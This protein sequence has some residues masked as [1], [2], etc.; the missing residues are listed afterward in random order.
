SN[1]PGVVR[2]VVHL[3]LWLA[4]SVGLV[5]LPRSP[6]LFALV[7]LDR[8]LIAS[9]FAPL[10]QA[11]HQ[12][13]FRWRRLHTLLASPSALAFG[14]PP[15]RSRLGVRTGRLSF[16]PLAAHPSLEPVKRPRAARPQRRVAA[17]LAGLREPHAVA[18]VHRVT[19]EA[20]DDRRAC[21]RSTRDRVASARLR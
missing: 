12:T 1:L 19:D 15:V 2:S 18:G 21:A 20:A 3:G 5:V 17:E 14:V 8:V 16:S 13:V 7:P 6:L 11:S 10:H 9:L 4:C